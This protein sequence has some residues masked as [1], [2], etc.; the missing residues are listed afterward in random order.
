[1]RKCDDG[2]KI[3]DMEIYEREFG[4]SWLLGVVFNLQKATS[5]PRD[6]YSLCLRALLQLP[7]I[8]PVG[9][10]HNANGP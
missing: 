2:R 5:L 6:Q 9:S 1:M 4:E 8:L 10:K 7:Q 3:S